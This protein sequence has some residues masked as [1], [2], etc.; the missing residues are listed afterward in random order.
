MTFCK[1]LV[2]ADDKDDQQLL[3]AAFT[4]LGAPV[5]HIVSSAREAVAYLQE[6]TR[7][8]DLPRLIIADLNMPEVSG[9]ELLQSL[10][11]MHRYQDIPVMVYSSSC[12]KDDIHGCLLQAAIEFFTKPS[13]NF[14]EHTF[15]DGVKSL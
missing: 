7:H 8:Q 13:A 9:Y 10:K 11:T 14:D 15:V 3:A 6:V 2:V 5:F 1:I 4:D 12:L